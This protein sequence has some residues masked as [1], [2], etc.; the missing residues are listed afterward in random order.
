M[1]KVENVILVKEILF[2]TMEVVFL[3]L[4]VLCSINIL[5][6]PAM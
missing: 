4:I 1:V 3:V 6:I 2:L 5:A